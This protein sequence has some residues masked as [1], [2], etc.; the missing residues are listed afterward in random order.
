MKSLDVST[1]NYRSTL[2]LW[3]LIFMYA[4]VVLPLKFLHIL[5]RRSNPQWIDFRRQ[6]R[7]GFISFW[8][9]MLVMIAA[10]TMYRKLQ[11]IVNWLEVQYPVSHWWFGCTC[12][13]VVSWRI[14]YIMFGAAF[15]FVLSGK[16]SHNETLLFWWVFICTYLSRNNRSFT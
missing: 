12:T 14:V 3:V 5:P 11:E 1:C 4:Y 8:F 13:Y 9:D 7:F 16:V 10:L 15:V 6:H 2:R